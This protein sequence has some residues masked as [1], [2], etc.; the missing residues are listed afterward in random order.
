[1]KATESGCTG[2]PDSKALSSFRLNVLG[3]IHIEKY[4]KHMYGLKKNKEK[5]LCN[6]H[7]GQD[8]ASP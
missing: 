6:H 3:D 4:I 1:M 7:P 5:H 8:I 2:L